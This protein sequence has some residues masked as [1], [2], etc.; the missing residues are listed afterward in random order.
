MS[1]WGGLG[2]YFLVFFSAVSLQW[3]LLLCF[4]I[5][6]DIRLSVRLEVQAAFIEFFSIVLRSDDNFKYPAWMWWFQLS[7]E[8]NSAS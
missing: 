6:A 3:K 1:T 4:S 5:T 2:S 8:T 7:S